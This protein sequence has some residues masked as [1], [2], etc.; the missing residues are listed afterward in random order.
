MAQADAAPRFLVHGTDGVLPPVE[1]E[2]LAAD[3]TLQRAGS[4]RTLGASDWIDLQQDGRPRPAPLAVPFVLLGSGDRLAVK[5]TQ[6]LRLHEGRLRFAPAEPLR[7]AAG[8]ELSLFRPYV[9]MLLLAVPEGAD[10]I[11]PLLARL[12]HEPREDDLVLL[13]NGDRIEGT[14][15]RLSDTD[16]CTARADGETI[17]I[18][19]HKLAGVAF[20]TT[21]LARPRP[22]TTHALAVLDGGT[23]LRLARV[24]F[25]ADHQRWSGRTTTGASV[26]WPA[27]ALIALDVLGGRAVYLSEM[28]PLAYKHLPYFGIAWPLGVDRAVDDTP[29]RVGAD[30]FDK[31]LSL[32]G[33]ARVSYRLDGKFAWFEATVALDP[34]ARRKGR[35]RLAVIIDGKRHPLADG[36]E[37]TADDA[38]VAV[39]VDVRS[40]RELALVVEN[41]SLGDVQVRV[42]WGGARLLRSR[43]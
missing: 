41:G 17:T 20:A 11:E 5:A 8:N 24:T 40:A 1:I 31:G 22:K 34:V 32:H 43:S 15:E 23:R 18:P 10:A 37:L 27:S 9:A 26:T 35:A 29:L 12:R 14:I 16:G 39:R 2:H 30:H 3:W 21:S 28:T 4:K 7:A 36:K 6:P 13:R 42:N 33:Q 38:P 25:D 19:W